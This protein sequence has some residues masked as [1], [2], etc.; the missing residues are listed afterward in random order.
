MSGFFRP[1]NIA[2]GAGIVGAAV[3]LPRTT[4]KVVGYVLLYHSRYLTHS[5]ALPHAH[6]ND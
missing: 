2:I 5:M 1:R 3:F 6:D 4:G